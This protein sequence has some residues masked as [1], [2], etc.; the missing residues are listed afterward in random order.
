MGGVSV[1]L[2][3]VL[4]DVAIATVAFPG[5]ASPAKAPISFVIDK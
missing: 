5:A 3:A 2:S 1:L 4:A